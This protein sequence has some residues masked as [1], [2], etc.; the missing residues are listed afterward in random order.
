MLSSKLISAVVCVILFS[1]FTLAQSSVKLKYTN[2]SLYAGIEVGS[3]GVKLSIVEIGKNTRKDG[4][5]NIVKD[6]AVN[7]DFISFTKPTA[8]NT[9]NALCGLYS[10][11]L[12]RYGVPAGNVFTLVSS[13]VKVQAEKNGKRNQIDE[14]IASFKEK[15][16]DKKRKVELIDVAE[17]ARLSHLGI[18]PEEQRY[19]TFLIDIGS[20][21]TKGGYF[22][23]GN[24]TDFKLFQ[25]TWGTKSIANATEK[26]LDESDKTLVAFNTQLN[27]VLLGVE[28][29]EINYAVNTSGAYPLSDNVAFSG[30]IVWSVA[31]FLHP[32]MADKNVVPVSFKEVYDFNERLFR[33]F[34]TT[35]VDALVKQI[36][37]DAVFRETAIKEINRVHAVFDQ[38]ALM[39]GTGLLL[40]LMRQFASI[41]ETKQFYFVKNS[42]VAWISA[43]VDQI[44][45]K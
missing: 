29:A 44:S 19:K 3:K 42:Q 41:Y 24:S 23:Y 9:L 8:D 7:T 2:S 22:P 39:A 40:K 21:N 10:T 28:N 35:S 36:K 1:S 30:G 18:I 12:N 25:L 37:G 20:G 26:R 4:T 17:E 5:L 34:E 32:E 11:A 13:G 27:R 14:L 43:Y 16:K 33:N 38:R 45:S 6:T 15:I 31:T